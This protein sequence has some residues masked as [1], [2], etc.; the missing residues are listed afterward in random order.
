MKYVKLKLTM[1]DKLR[2]LFL[3]V[4]P[5][6]LLPKIEIID[7]ILPRQSVQ[8]T[9]GKIDTMEEEELNNFIPFFDNDDDVTSNF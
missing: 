6:H 3:G 2:L 5:E 9:S 8:P 7:K 1:G 4:V